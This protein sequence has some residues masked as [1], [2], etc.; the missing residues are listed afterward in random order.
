MEELNEKIKDFILWKDN[1]KTPF[2][3]AYNGIDKSRPKI[4]YRKGASDKDWTIDEVFQFW[5]KNEEKE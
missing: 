2:E 4:M 1:P 3:I 5:L